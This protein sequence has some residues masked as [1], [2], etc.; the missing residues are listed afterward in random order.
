MPNR[1][2]IIASA[3]LAFLGIGAASAGWAAAHGL[4]LAHY[5][6]RGHLIVARRV[7]DSRKDCLKNAGDFLIPQQEGAIDGDSIVEIADLVSGRQ[8]GRQTDSEITYY[9][10]IGVPIQDLVTARHIERLA[11]AAGRGTEIEI[12]GDEG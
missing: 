2:R 11:I 6:A 7:I 3:F 10:S 8:P 9:K 5:D 1:Q 12:G 4:T